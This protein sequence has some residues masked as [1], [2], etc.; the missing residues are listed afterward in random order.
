MGVREADTVVG[1]G[2]AQTIVT[3]VERKTGY[4]ALYKVVRNRSALA[5]AAILAQLAAFQAMVK[6][7]ICDNGREFAAHAS[8]GATLGAAMYFA[9]PYCSWERGLNENTNGLIRQYFRKGSCFRRV[10]QA[11][12]D[13]VANKLNRLPSVRRRLRQQVG[14]G[15]LPPPRGSRALRCRAGEGGGD[16]GS[17]G[18]SCSLT[19][20]RANTAQ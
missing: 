3:L 14:A 8:M 20:V 9:S 18:T 19:W 5:S 6:T 1:R 12:L 10:R 16:A 4:T 2:H 7:I 15:P 17:A 11:D 13:R